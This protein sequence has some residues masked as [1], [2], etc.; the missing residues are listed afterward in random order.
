[1]IDQILPRTYSYIFDSRYNQ[2]PNSIFGIQ[3]DG[4]NFRLM[5]GLRKWSKLFKPRHNCSKVKTGTD[6]QTKALFYTFYTPG[7]S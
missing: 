7:F 2:T 4:K 5:S 1:V 3:T 6:P